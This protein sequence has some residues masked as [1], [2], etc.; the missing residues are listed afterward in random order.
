MTVSQMEYKFDIETLKFIWITLR[1]PEFLP[2]TAAIEKL[3]KRIIKKEW[4]FNSD[5]E[6]LIYYHDNRTSSHM[7]DVK[8]SSSLFDIRWEPV[9]FRPKAKSKSVSEFD[10]IRCEDAALLLI[11]MERIGFQTDAS[12]F[13]HQLLPGIR[14]RNK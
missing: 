12:L 8:K 10:A 14:S 13:V 11:L 7:F 1:Q 9:C 4:A 6:D 5:V 2:N 3:T